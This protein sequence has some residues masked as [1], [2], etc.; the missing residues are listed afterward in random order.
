MSVRRNS[1]LPKKQTVVEAETPEAPE[2][3]S[4]QGFGRHMKQCAQGGPDDCKASSQAATEV[5]GCFLEILGSVL[6][7]EEKLRVKAVGHV[8]AARA[9]VWP[10]PILMKG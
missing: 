2:M 6:E 3:K 1:F 5:R 7:E 9:A 4:F 8:T 10:F